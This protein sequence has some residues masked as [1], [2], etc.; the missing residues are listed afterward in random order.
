MD[1]CAH[2]Y[3]KCRVIMCPMFNR[4]CNCWYVSRTRNVTR[5]AKHRRSNQFTFPLV[6]CL[7]NVYQG[8][9]QTPVLE[10]FSVYTFRQLSYFIALLFSEVSLT[11]FFFQTSFPFLQWLPRE[12]LSSLPFM[13][14][15]SSLWLLQSIVVKDYF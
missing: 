12:S 7:F 1:D 5:A 10:I 4:H 14:P 15:M 8:N 3:P 2:D 9:V 11:S 6:G 13:A